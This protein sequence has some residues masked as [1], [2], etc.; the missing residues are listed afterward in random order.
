MAILTAIE[1][2]F[3][4]KDRKVLQKW[5]TKLKNIQK[6]LKMHYD[7]IGSDTIWATE[8]RLK[9]RLINVTSSRF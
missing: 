4:L 6:G 2:K 5:P 1:K 3:L 9:K 7:Q 8:I